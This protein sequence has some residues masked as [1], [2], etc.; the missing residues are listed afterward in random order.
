MTARQL[1][2]FPAR[3]ALD[4][5][6]RE[7][8]LAGVRRQAANGDDDWSIHETLTTEDTQKNKIFRTEQ[9]NSGV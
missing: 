9:S 1:D 7:R 6:A 4:E 2:S 8:R 5:V 3:Q